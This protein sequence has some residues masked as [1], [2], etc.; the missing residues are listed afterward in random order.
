[1]LFR[2][3]RYGLA[4]S[5]QPAI[6]AVL[7][8]LTNQGLSEPRQPQN[9]QQAPRLEQILT[10]ANLHPQEFVGQLFPDAENTGDLE[11]ANQLLMGVSE[12]TRQISQMNRQQA[13]QALESLNTQPP[14]DSMP[15]WFRDVGGEKRNFV[16]DYI[17]NVLTARIN[18]ITT[19]N[20]MR[21]HKRGGAITKNIHAMKAQLQRMNDGGQPDPVPVLKNYPPTEQSAQSALETIKSNNAKYAAEEARQQLR[22][23]VEMGQANKDLNA[24][25][26]DKY[27]HARIIAENK[28]KFNA[29]RGSGSVGGGGGIIDNTI[30]Q[31]L[32]ARNPFFANGGAVHMNDGGNPEFYTRTQRLPDN[33][34]MSD[35]G[36]AGQ[37]NDGDY[38]LGIQRQRMANEYRPTVERG[39]SYVEYG[40]PF[41]DGR[42]S[43]RI[44]KPNSESAPQGTYMGSVNYQKPLG[45]GNI[46]LGALASRELSPEQKIKLKMISAMYNE[47]LGKDSNISAGL[48][49]PIGGGKPMVNVRYDKSFKDGGDISIDEMRLLVT[50]KK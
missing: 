17:R 13:Q 18:E 14:E 3:E 4:G 7:E 42:L 20:A 27:E 11:V 47:Q 1:M 46:S 39:A 31:Q 2:S 35:M 9:V 32:G 15:N 50:R 28:A 16:V 40:H 34:E 22:P 6:D 8:R 36:I 21:G 26:I 41:A 44:I 38:R 30:K 5:S 12:T 43:G 23:I 24:G 19:P 10:D 33:T 29:M 49:K 48:I 25:R 37:A 45:D